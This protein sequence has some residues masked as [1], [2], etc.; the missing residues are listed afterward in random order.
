MG[1]VSRKSLA[2]LR[3]GLG[4]RDVVIAA[5]AGL[6]VGL[7]SS[8]GAELCKTMGNVS[9]GSPAIWLRA[10]LI[11]VAATLCFLLIM[12][13]WNVWRRHRG[14][15][16]VSQGRPCGLS[17]AFLSWG[18]GARFLV[19]LMTIV[20]LWVPAFL[21]LYPGG[22]ASDAPSQATILLNTGVV[23]LHWPAAHTLLVVGA[24]QLGNTIFGSYDAGVS[25]FCIGQAVIIAAALAY[26]SGRLMAWGVPV[27]FVLICLGAIVI[28]PVVQGYAFTMAK[29]SLFGAFFLGTLVCAAE[30]LF[31]GRSVTVPEGRDKPLVCAVPRTGGQ[32]IAN[33]GRQAWDMGRVVLLVVCVT[34]MCLLRKQSLYVLVLAAPLIL[35]ALSGW[36]LRLEFVLTITAGAASSYLFGAIVGALLPTQPDS[37]REMLSLPSQQIV[38]TYMVDYDNLSSEEIGRIGHYYNLGALESGRTSDD[39]WD[40]VPPTGIGAYWN[41]QTGQ[42]YLEPIADPAKGALTDRAFNEDKLGYIALWLD[43]MRG[44]EGLYLEAFLWNIAGYIYPSAQLAN[45]W[46]GMPAWN[47]FGLTIDDGGLD[48][49]VS[50]FATSS[51]FP[52]YR[53]WLYG[54]TSSLLGGIPILTPWV[55]MALPFYVLLVVGVILIHAKQYRVLAIWLVPALYLLVLF[56]APV[57]CLRYV[58]PL[59]LC[60]PFL[61]GLPFLNGC[62]A[63]KSGVDY[64]RS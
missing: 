11:A 19:L 27:P 13:V 15:D 61:L 9:F 56:L 41:R 52:S 64:I 35:G 25:L 50:N 63:A 38:R 62:R 17:R 24:L 46:T 12:V 49:Q 22:Y 28:N 48:N 54:A 53:N 26:A 20:V 32:L 29:D 34:M 40:F 1:G 59:F 8:L 23:D 55:H 51:L 36:K 43:L 57:A 44:H 58:V 30:L 47:E 5:S 37:P 42:G 60:V 3:E 14:D 31:L 7:S 2:R 16:L 18:S 6:V 33:S 39:G 45:F 21:A 10:I 4:I